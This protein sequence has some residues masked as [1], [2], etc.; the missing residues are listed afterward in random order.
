MYE[1]AHPVCFPRQLADASCQ[2]SKRQVLVC[3][4]PSL[5]HPH[6]LSAGLRVPALDE[7]SPSSVKRPW[8]H[9]ATHRDG[10]AT[11]RPPPLKQVAH[12]VVSPR[13]LEGAV[14]VQRPPLKGLFVRE[15]VRV[16]RGCLLRVHAVV[17]AAVVS[18]ASK[19]E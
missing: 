18:C 14:V 3:R 1:A 5:Q 12:L 19:L 17:A 9:G 11:S 6:K 16:R 4:F 13:V 7:G 10:L 8:G 2:G 15:L